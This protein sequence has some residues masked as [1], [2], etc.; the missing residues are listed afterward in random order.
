MIAATLCQIGN[1]ISLSP[2]PP[3]LNAQGEFKACSPNCDQI[4]V[5]APD[6][7]DLIWM[8]TLSTLQSRTHY[9]NKEWQKWEEEQ[10]QQSQERIHFTIILED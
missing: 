2:T 9:N 4:N 3:K 8:V 6:E 10:S 5:A 7:T 1:F